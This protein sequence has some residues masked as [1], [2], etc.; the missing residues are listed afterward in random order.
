[1]AHV[2]PTVS[3]LAK[4]CVLDQKTEPHATVSISQHLYYVVYYDHNSNF[5]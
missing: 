2:A 3:A 1:M 4:T 5:C